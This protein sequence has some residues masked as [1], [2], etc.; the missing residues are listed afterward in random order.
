MTK[1]IR[2]ICLILFISFSGSLHAVSSFEAGVD[3]TGQTGLMRLCRSKNLEKVKEAVA[4][5]A[6]LTARD[7]FGLDAIIYAAINDQRNIVEY[8]HQN[9]ADQER[10][11]I[12]YL[13]KW[14]TAE[15]V[16]H[17]IRLGCN[18]NYTGQTGQT[19]LFHALLLRNRPLY[20]RLILAGAD[21]HQ[22]NKKGGT[23]LHQAILNQDGELTQSLLNAGMNVNAANED[24]V[25]PLHLAAKAQDYKLMQELLDLGADVNTKDENDATPAFIAVLLQDVDMMKLLLKNG[26]DV[27]I[28]SKWGAPLQR[29]AKERQTE[30]VELIHRAGTHK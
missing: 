15:S 9:G 11:D 25:P 17:L 27:S 26:V 21:I 23:V 7:P 16:E 12:S 20:D 18:V 14:H 22:P 3:S 19:P 28:A 30:M 10:I 13:L 5:G 2:L 6:D 4:S 1:K 8:L 29:A 24:G